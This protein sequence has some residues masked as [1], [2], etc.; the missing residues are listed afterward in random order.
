MIDLTRLFS[1]LA[2][3]ALSAQPAL[4][5]N[6]IS[7]KAVDEVAVEF[8]ATLRDVLPGNW[9]GE[10]ADGTYG[11][12]TSEWRPLRVDYH[13][14]AGDTAIIEDYVTVG[15]TDVYMSTV[16]HLDNNDIRATHFCGAMNHPRM[17]A[18]SVDLDESLARFD[19]VDVSNLKDPRDYHSRGLD[20]RVVDRDNVRVTFHG[21]QDG[22][23]SSRVFVLRRMGAD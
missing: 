10:V 3:A 4:A 22:H 12:T 17:I 1:V 14:T 7:E 16:Y 13:L 6:T 18:R 8:F 11:N 19:F 9:E 20:L 5:A 21:L 2:I 15:G 23:T